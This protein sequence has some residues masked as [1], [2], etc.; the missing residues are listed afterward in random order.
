MQK[1]MNAGVENISAEFLKIPSDAAKVE[2]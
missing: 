1:F 2:A